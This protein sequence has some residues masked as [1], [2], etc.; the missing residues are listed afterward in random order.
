MISR[1]E[2]PLASI[3]SL[4]WHFQ[5][6]TLS[7]LTAMAA[8]SL[9]YCNHQLVEAA[10]PAARNTGLKVLP[11]AES[12]PCGRIYRCLMEVFCIQWFGS[13]NAAV[14]VSRMSLMI[15]PFTNFALCSRIRPA[16]VNH[17]PQCLIGSRIIVA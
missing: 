7:F 5:T 10:S 16:Y 17:W 8:I 11:G 12:N 3:L 14:V 2:P 15:T 1:S 9:C 6:Y 4:S 13:T